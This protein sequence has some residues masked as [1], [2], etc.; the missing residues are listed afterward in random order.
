MIST[1]SP[2]R[3]DCVFSPAELGNFSGLPVFHDCFCHECYCKGEN[4]NPKHVVAFCR[5]CFK[6]HKFDAINL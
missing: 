1:L 5:N 3:E 4:K 2:E 6:D